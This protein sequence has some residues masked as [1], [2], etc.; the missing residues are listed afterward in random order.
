MADTGVFNQLSSG[1]SREERRRLLAAITSPGV[2]VEKP[3]YDE[4][5]F[6]GEDICPAEAY[7]T[8]SP[9]IRLIYF[10]TGIARGKK[11][12]KV[13]EDHCIGKIGRKLE[14]RA[15]H[16]FNYREGSLLSGFERELV[17]LKEDVRFFHNALDQSVNRDRGAFYDFL[18]SREAGEQYDRL[19][20]ETDPEMF[21]SRKRNATERE[22][23]QA[24]R[25]ALEKVS[26]SFS[27]AERESLYSDARSLHCLQA[28]CSYPF[29]RLLAYFKTESQAGTKNQTKG[30]VCPVGAA[31]EELLQLNNT[32]Y[33]LKE[34]P[35]L[36]LLESLFVFCLKDVEAD[37]FQNDMDELLSEAERSLNTLREFNRSIPLT[38]I[39][40]CA[41]RDLNIEPRDLSGGEDWL[42]IFRDYWK[43]RIDERV[44]AYIRRSK[45]ADLLSKFNV[46]FRGAPFHLL[47]SGAAFPL[48]LAF[49]LSFL[50]GFC[51]TVFMPAVDP[52]LCLLEM[53]AQFGNQEA[54][55]AFFSC[56]K[57]LSFLRENIMEME[58][59]ATPEGE[60]GSE[61]T[62]L[63]TA[64][65]DSLQSR[66]RMEAILS[67]TE[68]SA[69]SLVSRARNALQ[70]LVAILQTFVKP[71]Q[72][73][74]RYGEI[75]NMGKLK[76]R[77][78]GLIYG[79]TVA[80]E[81][82]D[83]ALELMNAIEAMERYS[84]KGDKL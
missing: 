54:R 24:G 38:T 11:S 68:K 1:L 15:P 21:L 27:K 44:N 63:K 84:V 5:N 13:F 47:G 67:Q 28:L 81:R 73:E 79:M 19:I 36:E 69:K 35:S 23:R 78:N 33:S 34:P 7:D 14:K 72:P 10:L 56:H 40:R 42:S 4:R 18:V 9:F 74:D 17:S 6:R 65:S 71:P 41:L 53:E 16:L 80:I 59:S 55:E 75:L 57:D 31:K 29:D 60:L 32:L 83:R 76:K 39:M 22:L 50:E 12:R 37:N 20:D 26:N 45:Q 77:H 43:R 3:L 51:S 8:L 30:P 52:V 46:F 66:K 25:A 58:Q 49:G 64:S 62:A 48:P 82:M 70:T 2:A 61:Y